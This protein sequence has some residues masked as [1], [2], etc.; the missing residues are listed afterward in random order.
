MIGKKNFEPF[1][2]YLSLLCILGLAAVTLSPSAVYSQSLL[3][4]LEKEIS[5]LVQQA[6]PAVTTV[7]AYIPV[8]KSST[9]ERPLFSFFTSK[10]DLPAKARENYINVGTGL[11]L[12]KNGYIVTRSSV[13]A[14][15]CSIRVRFYTG[16]EV[17][18]ELIGI[19]KNKGVG[20]LK[21]VPPDFPLVAF[22]HPEALTAGSWILVI[23]NSLGV[24]PAVSLG[25]VSAIRENGLIQITANIDPGNNGSPVLNSEGE[26]IG[27]VSGRIDYRQP[28]SKDVLLASNAA[29]VLPITQIYAAAKSLLDKYAREHG[30]LGMTVVPN[31]DD[32][33]HPQISKIEQNS[34]AQRAGLK[35]GDIILA[36]DH[37]ILDHYYALKGLVKKDK[38]GKRAAIQVKRGS[39]TLNLVIEVGKMN[40]GQI[41]EKIPY[42][43]TELTQINRPKSYMPL[44]SRLMLEKRL[45]EMERQIRELRSRII[46]RP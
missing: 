36:Y 14:Q 39:D 26:V 31:P 24:A 41:F 5:A 11:L 18:A 12:H 8:E 29:L 4:N 34:P 17:D 22:G 3:S 33:I 2:Q 20:L 6:E 43:S 42:R 40:L 46:K 16:E 23:G 13:I 37:Q 28:Q 27:M 35:I 9:S 7:L 21:V 19:D 44:E 38:P 15:A 45:L 1:G 32:E 10:T 25:N 30:W